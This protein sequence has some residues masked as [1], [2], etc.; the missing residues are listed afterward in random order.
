MK[1]IY[2]FSMVL[3]MAFSTDLFAGAGDLFNYDKMAVEAELADLTELENYVDNNPTKTL[4]VLAQ[5]GNQLLTGLNLSGPI[6]L[7][8]MFDDPPLGIPSF[9]WG[10]AFG[11]VGVA[12]VY[13]VTDEDNDET[14]KAFYGCIASTVVFGV[15]YAVWWSSLGWFAF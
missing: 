13:F 11:V 12:I 9:L 6:G 3:L 14:K 15:L 1:Q 2:L 4:S 5:E 8:M 7:S 10:C